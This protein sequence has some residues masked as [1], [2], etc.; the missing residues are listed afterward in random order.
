MLFIIS[1]GMISAGVIRHCQNNND[2][3][4]ELYLKHG[5]TVK[6]PET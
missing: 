3:N 5:R 6:K 2:T 4:D 1:N